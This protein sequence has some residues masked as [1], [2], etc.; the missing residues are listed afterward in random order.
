L[1]IKSRPL[2]YLRAVSTRHT[3]ANEFGS[4]LPTPNASPREVTEEQTMKR[5][6]MYGGETRAMYLEH[7]AILGLLPTPT[8]QEGQKITGTENQDSMT[9]RVRQI[10]GTTSQLNPRFVGEMMGFPDNWTTLPFLIG[11]K[12]Q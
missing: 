9:K 10:T 8:A 11:D 6:E 1:G 3:N 2:L 5:K 12:N 4:L 7:F